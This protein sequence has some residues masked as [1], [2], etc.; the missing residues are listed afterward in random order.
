[1]NNMAA[2]QKITRMWHGRTHGKHADR[3]LEYVTKT[4]L[5]GYRKTE[6]NLSAKILRRIEGDVCHF[7]TVTE[8]DSYDSIIKFAG[9]E[10]RKA[11]YYPEDDNYLLE[12]EEEVQHFE[13]FE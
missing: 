5:A 3:Y 13:T 10:Y 11:R 4:G 1:M 8:W 6:G 9:P 12:F 7:L 2:A